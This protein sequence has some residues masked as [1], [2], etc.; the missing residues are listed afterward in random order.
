MVLVRRA[1]A[2]GGRPAEAVAVASLTS[3][4]FSDLRPLRRRLDGVRIVQLGESSHGAAEYNRV[5][6]RLVRFLHEEMG[7]DV[8]AFESDPYQCALADRRAGEV[9]ARTTLGNCV[10]GVW[11]TEEMV[12]LFEYLRETRKTDRPLVL[13]GYDIQPIGPNKDRRPDYIAAVAARLDPARAEAA[14]ALDREFLD[15]YARPSSERRKLFRER[16]ADWL[17]RYTE[18]H[19]FLVDNEKALLAAHAGSDD[20]LAPLLAQQTVWSTRQYLMQ[21]TSPT[22]LIY[23]ESRDWGM[24]QNLTFLAERLYPGKRIIAWAHNAHVQHAQDRIDL[25]GVEEPALAS[26]AAGSWLKAR[27]GSRLFTIGL[28]AADGRMTRNDRREIEVSP[29]K[30]GSLEARPFAP[31]SVGTLFLGPTDGSFDPFWMQ[32]IT[33]KYWGAADLPMILGEQYD[34]VLLLRS[35]TPPR[36]LD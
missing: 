7:F 27:Y 11:H 6:T 5:K 13:A 28:Y 2:G 35:V 10:V 9:P 8:L 26:R 3:T 24:A 14:R 16:R 18:L 19:R 29:V 30:P 12:E 1:A 31:G 33:A 17:R 36:Y 34:A 20:P 4:D 23:A 22:N 25:T 21:Q 32:T 15:A